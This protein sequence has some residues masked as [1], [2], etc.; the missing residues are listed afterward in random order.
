MSS[1]YKT[2]EID[3]S[4]LKILNEFKDC[5]EA[6]AIVTK[7]DVKGRIRYVNDLFCKISGYSPVMPDGNRVIVSRKRPGKGATK[8]KKCASKHKGVKNVV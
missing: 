5:L 1:K 8:G 7:T 3:E 2:I 6:S 4:E